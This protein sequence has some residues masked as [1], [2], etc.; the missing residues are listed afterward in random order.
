MNKLEFYGIERRFKSLVKSYLTG[1][2]QKVTII[3]LI[4]LAL[5]NGN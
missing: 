4:L 1:I 5:Q 2:Y 3:I